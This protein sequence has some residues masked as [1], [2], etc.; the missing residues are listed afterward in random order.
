MKPTNKEK[1]HN[2]QSK[3]I[4]NFADKIQYMCT[5]SE[6]IRIISEN[7]DFIEREYGVKSIMLFGSTARGDNR[8]DS[9]VDILVEMPP[10]MV[11]LHELKNY[12]ERILN[13]SVDLIRKHSHMSQSFL[14][15]ISKDAI[16]IL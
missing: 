4:I 16:Q 13:V 1:K 11:L 7:K 8:A 6:C 15:Q 9:D 3:K 10:K 5:S 14:S 2:N 12:L